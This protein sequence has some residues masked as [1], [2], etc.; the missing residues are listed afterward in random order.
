MNS[1]SVDMGSDPRRNALA[2]MRKNNAPA[3]ATVNSEGHP[4]VSIVFS[5]TNDNFDIFFECRLESSKYKNIMHCPFV[6]MAFSKAQ[7]LKTVQLKGKAERIEDFDKE[8]EVMREMVEMQSGHGNYEVP[9]LKM[10]EKGLTNDIVV[11][12][13]VPSQITY[14]DYSRS[15][16]ADSRP[17][18]TAIK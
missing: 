1:T 12:K 14:A 16:K 6:S 10:F 2:F 17:L 3:L 18:F 11:F 9:V 4:D 13:I 8:Q 5:L 7:E 15:G